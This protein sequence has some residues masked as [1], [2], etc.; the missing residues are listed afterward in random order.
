VFAALHARRT[1]AATARGIVVD[2]RIGDTFI[3][4]E[5]R[6]DGPVELTV[7]ARGYRDLARI[8]ILRDGV[9]AH[10][11]TP[12]LDLPAGWLAVPLRVEWGRSA[13]ALDWRGHLTVRDGEVL[14][15]PYWPRDVREVTRTS[16]R[17]EA[18]TYA[19]GGGGLYA[20][21]R[22][23]LD[24][25]VVGPPSAHVEVVTASGS[26]DAPLH[27]LLTEV[28]TAT[29]PAAPADGVLRLQPGTGGLSSLGSRARSVT[30]VDPLGGPAFYYV[31]V[32]LVDG[33]MAWSSPIWVDPT[34]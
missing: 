24:V 21:T 3:G 31:R 30:W 25:T 33:E 2:A 4:G 5:R 23:G 14:Q 12:T 27:A 1:I 19:F 7:H 13:T 20:A 22:G 16:V 34:G 29:G 28:V 17:W 9:P 8:D 11:L 6:Q 10:V 32:F 15:T 26:V 18:A